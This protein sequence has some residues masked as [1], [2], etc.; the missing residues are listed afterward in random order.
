MILSS[1]QYEIKED[2]Y[3]KRHFTV[4]IPS[5]YG[6]YHEL[7]FD[8]L[9]LMLR[10]ESMVN[11]LFESLIDHIDLTLITKATFYRIHDLFVLFN[12]ALT[13]DGI[14][15]KEFERQLSFL[16]HSLEERGFT[17]T[18]YLDIF[19]GFRQAVKNIF[20]DCF[21][22]MHDLNLEKIFDTLSSADLLPKYRFS[23]DQQTGPD[24]MRQQIS[25]QFFRDRLA[26]SLGLQSL[27]N[28]LTRILRTLFHQYKELPKNRVHQLLLFDHQR[29][30]T[31]IETGGDYARGAIHLGAKGYSLIK[32]KAFGMQVPPGFIITTEVFRGWEIINSYPPAK[33]NFAEQ[34]IEHI[35]RLETKT[36]RRFGD[37]ER[38]LLFSVRSGA[39][40]SQPGMMNTFLNVG[41]DEEIAE[42]LS[43]RTNNPWFAW[44]NYRRFLQCYGMALGM[45]RDHFDAIIRGVKSQVGVPLKR[46]LSGAQM[47]ELALKYKD[48]IATAGFSLDAIEDPMDQLFMV[49]Q[50]VLESWYSKR[51]RAYREIMGISEDW[52]TA[53]TVQSMVYGNRSRQ[54]GSGVVFTHNPRWSGDTLRLWGDFTIGNQGEDVVSGLVSTL[55]ISITQQDVEMR[56]SDIILETHFPAIYEALKNWAVELTEHRGWSPQEMEFT[57]QGPTADQLYLLQTRDMAIRTRKRVLAFVADDLHQKIYIGNGIGVSGGAMSGR[58]VFDLKEIETWRRKEPDT[59]LILLRYDTVPDDIREVNAADGLLTARGGLTSHAAVVAHRLDKTCVVGCDSLV[60]DEDQKM[61]Q[62]GKIRL[63]SGDYISIDG[64]AGTVYQGR[65]QIKEEP[66]PEKLTNT[67]G[68]QNDISRPRNKK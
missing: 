49:I 43:N 56:D 25:E 54:S 21:Y 18:Q 3:K 6:R 28:F 17:F 4:D 31:D 33:R 35:H 38:P 40:I 13:I 37:P 67:M 39:A 62:F 46:Y 52:G 44:D 11:V 20:S 68:R 22:N 34:V 63:D 57:F 8:A 53:V 14:P 29:A 19:K 15:T 65:I 9:G 26:T 45:E 12:Q 59:D 2:I 24:T 23:V 27:D 51:A 58:I 16:S 47:K 7:K 41:M 42:G 66:N 60:C 10:I 36:N 5:M 64:R 30:I 1:E 61:C 48:S 32:L 55:P 50:Y